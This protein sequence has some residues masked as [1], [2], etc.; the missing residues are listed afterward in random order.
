MKSS[1]A[2][3]AAKA[4]I[5]FVRWA[6]V[7]ALV[8]SA[9]GG[10]V[11]AAFLGPEGRAY[12]P[13][14]LFVVQ[15]WAGIL[16][17]HVLPETAM[18][19]TGALLAPRARRTIAVALAALHV[20]LFFWGHVLATGGPWWSWTINYTHFTLEALGAVLGVVYIFWL[21]ATSATRGLADRSG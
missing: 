6:A 15:Q 3:T 21:E 16:R 17:F 2:L 19:V 7:L 4:V 13:A 11:Y 9:L 18:V 14:A 1:F 20:P 12:Q 10:L 5:Q 8:C